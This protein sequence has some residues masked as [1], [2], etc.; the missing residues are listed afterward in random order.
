[1]HHSIQDI[2]AIDL[3]SII[4]LTTVWKEESLP[5]AQN[6]HTIMYQVMLK[7]RKIS[8]K[9]KKKNTQSNKH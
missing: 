4:L 9:K 7:N 8:V 6:P 3:V 2:Q 1:M 5:V